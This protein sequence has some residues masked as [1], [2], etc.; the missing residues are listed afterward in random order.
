MPAGTS[1]SYLQV[2][3]RLEG[4]WQRLRRPVP[5]ASSAQVF[6]AFSSMALAYAMLQY[7]TRQQ[8]GVY[9]IVMLLLTVGLLVQSA[10]IVAPM[11]LRHSQRQL[12]T[13]AQLDHPPV[14][15]NAVAATSGVA[16]VENVPPVAAKS[17]SLGDAE[18]E[19]FDVARATAPNDDGQ[20]RA[21]CTLNHYLSLLWAGIAA[22]MSL[23]LGLSWLELVVVAFYVFVQ[24]ERSV[25]RTRLQ[26]RQ[27][28]HRAAMVDLR[29]AG[30]TL[31]LLVVL[32]VLAQVN[33]LTLLGSS[34]LSAL[35]CRYPLSFRGSWRLTAQVRS[36]W[37]ESYRHQ[38]RAALTGAMWSELLSNSHSYTV[39]CWLGALAYA[40]VAAAAF[41]FR[42]ATVLVQGM[43]QVYRVQITQLLQQRAP[44]ANV[45]RC[46]QALSRQLWLCF[47]SDM[48]A[49]SILLWL[50]PETIW[51]QGNTLEFML[52]LLLTA[53]LVALRLLR[54]V[55]MLMLQGSGRYALLSRLQRQSGLIALLGC[56]LAL[57][58]ADGSHGEWVAELFTGQ[59]VAVEQV[60]LEQA[61][62]EQVASEQLVAICGAMAAVL[63]A[64]G[65][66][67]W[68][69]RRYWPARSK[70]VIC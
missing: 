19:P 44:E 50:W 35:V 6:S 11:L 52:I 60:T 69:L 65:L 42:P 41:V 16:M 39:P 32:V 51:P 33:L 49:A 61:A 10:I 37:R 48:L 24:L 34:L 20:I 38:G 70:A 15:A 58:F 53:G 43:L 2:Q 5:M 55:P 17:H 8:F 3:Q 25:Q 68:R 28:F 40:P 4:L 21:L 1:G 45:L 27:E 54:Q 64:E 62:V 57:G 30:L 46:T 47:A 36:H 23:G 22:C 14:N 13:Q 56:L 66:L 12:F 67:A 59:Q 63:A 18:A 7:G 26:H 31:T 29:Y 9:S